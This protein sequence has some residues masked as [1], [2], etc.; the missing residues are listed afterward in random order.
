MTR[1]SEW[2]SIRTSK[3]KIRF[4]ISLKHFAAAGRHGRQL[5]HS[6]KKGSNFPNGDKRA[7][8]KLYGN[9]Y[10][11]ASPWIS[12]A[13]H[14]M[15]EHSVLAARGHGKIPMANGTASICLGS[16]GRL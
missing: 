2:C 12:C 8:G 9:N 6:N 7:P 15:L 16:N 3:S 1:R 10:G 13:I 14:V 4:A 5:K 11:T